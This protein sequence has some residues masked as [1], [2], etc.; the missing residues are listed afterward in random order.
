MPDPAIQI[1]NLVKV[2]KERSESPVRA[3][4]G[5]S[6]E[7][8]SGEIFGL[9]GRNGAG[10]TTLLRILTTLIRP[11]GGSAR[12]F[13]FD[14]ERQGLDVR[15][16][17]CAVLQENALET[18][19]TV[20]DNLTTYARFHAIPPYERERRAIKAMEMFG[21]SEH[22]NKKVMD[23]SGG[24]KRRLQVA[25]VFTIDKPIVFLDEATTG[26]DPVNKRAVLNAIREQADKGRTIFL[27][28]H[29][30]QE[31]EE[32]C[33]R[34]AVINDG[35]V[36]ASG[37]VGTIKSLASNVF[38]LVIT[39]ESLTEE[40]L[41]QLRELP[42]FRFEQ[43]GNTVELSVSDVESHLLETLAALARKSRITQLEINSGSL[44]D[45]FIALLGKK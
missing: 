45:A 11:T 20:K 14:V 34:I 4:D 9:L 18:F 29:I 23:L 19:L 38:E 26:M 42:A 2:Y 44:E 12:V 1:T 10:K 21:L 39:F 28:T 27:T 17:I 16:N 25:K 3:L 41:A 8:R 35:A 36:I 40:I 32:L 30:L 5:L 43:A 33:D 24:L 37:D 6:L 15:K 22:A 31:A 7:V 13:G